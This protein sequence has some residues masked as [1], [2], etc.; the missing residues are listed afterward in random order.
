MTLSGVLVGYG[1]MGS[2]HHAKL[3]EL[4]ARIVAVVDPRLFPSDR[5][6]GAEVVSTVEQAARLRPDFWDICAPT[7]E[8]GAMLEAVQS[9]QAEANI[10][11]EK[12]VCAPG[13]AARVRELLERHRGRAAVNEQYLSSNVLAQV[14]AAV[15]RLRLSPLRVLVE[16]SKHR[17]QDVL[18][19]RF[20]DQDLG[21]LGYEGPHLIALIAELG[22]RTGTDLMPA[23]PAEVTF[24]GRW[25]PGL[26]PPQDGAQIRY[27]SR[28]ECEAVL[29]TSLTGRIGHRGPGEDDAASGAADLAAGTA[30]YR[31]LSVTA[32]DPNGLTWEVT[33]TFEPINGMTRNRGTITLNCAER[34]P[35]GPRLVADDSLR[36]H[37]RRILR[38]FEG[39]A[40]NPSPPEAALTQLALLH[41]WAR[42]ATPTPSMPQP[43]PLPLPLGAT[44]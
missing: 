22:R 16:M 33:G 3:T 9:V 19:G 37:L 35:I 34:P 28:S 6:L 44:S 42:Q 29:Y 23:G 24:H 39:R 10:V 43:L 4:G 25:G 21:A 26:A 14:C 30:R 31:A 15:V 20:Q 12:P 2:L 1:R 38:Y 36:T 18:E 40:P 13:E 5:P 17:G 32:T 8:H 27:R 7:A 41:T 11:V